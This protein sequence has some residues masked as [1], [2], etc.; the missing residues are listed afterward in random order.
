MN[1][2]YLR[3][4]FHTLCTFLRSATKFSYSIRRCSSSGA[5][6]IAEGWTVDVACGAH[7]FRT[8]CPRSFVKRY[9]PPKI[10]AAAV[11]PRHTMILG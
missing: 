1:L 6:K 11:A 3:R 9:V 7:A 5:R 4:P 10:D 8:N 2:A